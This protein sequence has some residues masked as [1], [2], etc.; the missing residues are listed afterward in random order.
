[1]RELSF[2]LISQTMTWR[3][4]PPLRNAKGTRGFELEG[5]FFR[6]HYKLITGLVHV[7]EPVYN[8]WITIKLSRQMPNINGES[9]A[10]LPNHHQL[11][12]PV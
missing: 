12:C 2:H 1:M 5:H 6:F 9:I 10:L 3:S 7:Y 8:D 4:G 11:T